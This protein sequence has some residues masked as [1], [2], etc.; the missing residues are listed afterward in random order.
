M[1]TLLTP[2]LLKAQFAGGDGSEANPYQVATLE[3]LQAIGEHE[4]L[5]KHFIQITDIDATGTADWNNGAG[6]EPIG[7]QEHPF[8][9]TYG[10][11]GFTIDGLHINRARKNDTGLFGRIHQGAVW[12]LKMSNVSITGKDN[13]GGLAGA[14]S[15]SIYDV[16]VSGS[17]TGIQFVGGI[18]GS[19]VTFGIE[20]SALI[21]N[22]S[23]Q[24]ISVVGNSHVGGLA[25]FGSPDIRF[26]FVDGRVEATNGFVGGLVGALW[27][28]DYSGHIAS[29]YALADVKGD[30]YVGGIA[31]ELV[32][33][34]E[35]AE[36]VEDG[37][38]VA[39]AQS[40]PCRFNEVYSAGT[41]EGE[42]HVG[43]IAG[44]NHSFLYSSIYWDTDQTDFEQN[45]IEEENSENGIGLTTEQM[46]GPDAEVHLQGFDF[47]TTWAT[48]NGYPVHQ[49]HDSVLISINHLRYN[50]GEVGVEDDAGEKAIL[51]KN[52]GNTEVEISAELPPGR[53]GGFEMTT[54]GQGGTLMPGEVHAIMVSFKP[55]EVREYSGRLELTHTARN[56]SSPMV[57]WFQGKGAQTTSATPPGIPFQ[58]VLHQ[59]YPNPFNPVAVIR[60]DLP[61]DRKVSLVVYDVMGRRVATLVDRAMPAGSH[62]ALFD[63]SDLAG[64]VYLYRLTAGDLT[65]TRQ[66]T[67]VK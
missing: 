22:S 55:G 19:S 11:N 53:F 25:G 51:I 57:I 65:Q 45:G 6:F 50:F 32:L 30:T 59:N 21:T 60:Y 46:T 38:A 15:G 28:N 13:T 62:T 43:A 9:G 52:V 12:R 48:T 41:V 2:M 42:G 3:Q 67:V 58:T 16:H 17:I 35:T 7:D 27:C 18:A 49:P 44:M 61:E 64:G 66:M 24:N 54:D 47:E 33:V 39:E 4:H 5:D 14:H 40:M 34:L 36:K 26:S 63:A 37:S 56:W 10:G 1:I 8:T 29:S 23:A 20:R 31:G